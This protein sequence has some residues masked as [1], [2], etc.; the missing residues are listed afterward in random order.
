[1]QGQP[2]H[3][4]EEKVSLVQVK[5]GGWKEMPNVGV[6]SP[7]NGTKFFF[8]N[9]CMILLMVYFSQFANEWI[10]FFTLLHLCILNL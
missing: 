5:D 8:V 4:I 10:F 7:L 3:L 1:M 6:L 2:Q 9:Y